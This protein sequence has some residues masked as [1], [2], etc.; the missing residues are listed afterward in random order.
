L[1]RAASAAAAV[2]LFAAAASAHLEGQ[3]AKAERTIELRLDESPIRVR[4]RIGLDPEAAA[5]ERKRADRDGDGV[6]SSAEGNARLDARSAEL[7]RA[8]RVCTGRTFEDLACRELSSRQISL[9]EADGWSTGPTGHL[10]LAWTFTLG[11]AA[12]ELGALRLEDAVHM[13]E[14][15]L[16]D[17]RIQP[18][19][20]RTLLAAGEG[21]TPSGV[22]Q[23]LTWIEARRG[24]GPRIVSAAWPPPERRWPAAVA[25]ATLAAAGGLLY[26]TARRKHLG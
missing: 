23:R 7:L 1:R 18:P 16:T 25:V 19:R 15:E 2:L 14:I 11:M 6:V 17:V 21:R 10:H 8:L 26:W 22:T 20:E 12:A 3:T 4:Y 5:G 9:V 24:Q 13:P